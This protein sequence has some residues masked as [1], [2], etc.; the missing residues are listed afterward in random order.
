MRYEHDC[1]SLQTEAL[2]NTKGMDREC[3]LHPP[4]HLRLALCA[5]VSSCFGPKVSG[6]KERSRKSWEQSIVDRFAGSCM[7]GLSKRTQPLSML[8]FTKQTVVV[9]V[10]VAHRVPYMTFDSDEWI[11]DSTETVGPVSSDLSTV[12]AFLCRQRNGSSARRSNQAK[13]CSATVVSLCNLV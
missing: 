8:S 4:L 9:S 10:F 5:S 13:R 1:T 7:D 6:R 12:T 3:F 11:A 2:T